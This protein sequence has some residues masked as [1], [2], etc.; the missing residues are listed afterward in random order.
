MTDLQTEIT[1]QLLEDTAT[2]VRNVLADFLPTK[3]MRVQ[4]VHQPKL[5]I[6][7]TIEN[8]EPVLYPNFIN[9]KAVLRPSNGLRRKLGLPVVEEDR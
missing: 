2:A 7:I 8:Q 4:V 9:A 6:L 5:G 1:M 3:D